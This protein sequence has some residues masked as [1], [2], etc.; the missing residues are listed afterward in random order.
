MQPLQ[1]LTEVCH[2]C[3]LHAQY[4]KN[5]WWLKY[6]QKKRGTCIKQVPRKVVHSAQCLP[7]LNGG[8]AVHDT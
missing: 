3:F 2:K 6:F 4:K 8:T 7:T 5:D 1:T